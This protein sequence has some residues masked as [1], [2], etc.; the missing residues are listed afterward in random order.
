[1]VN[2]QSLSSAITV[3]SNDNINC[4]EAEAVGNSI[5]VKLD[6]KIVDNCFIKRKDQVRTFTCLQPVIE[7]KK[8]TVHNNPMVLFNR[9][10]MLIK[11]EE[12][13]VNFFKYELT[14]ELASLFKDGKMRK[15]NKV[16]L[17]NRILQFNMRSDTTT[18]DVYVVYGGALLNQPN[19]NPQCTF[20]QLLE[21]YVTSRYNN[22]G[23]NPA[24]NCMFKVNNRTTRTRCEI[25]SKLTIKTPERR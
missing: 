5:Q 23:S 15:A 24:G 9:L 2:L 17:R 4:D 8:E 21:Q 7:L 3:S 25:C 19:W 22:G 14:P 1:M 10:T 18:S 13:R 12:E 11:R 20:N 6:C 16:D